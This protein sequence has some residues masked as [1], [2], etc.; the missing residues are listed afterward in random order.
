G[1]NRI[2]AEFINP[3]GSYGAMCGNGGRA[4]TAFAKAMG[5]RTDADTDILLTL[6][7][8]RYTVRFRD[9]NTIEIDFP[10]PRAEQDL[11][12]ASLEGIDIP[13]YYVDVHSDHVVI[14]AD[15]QRVDPRPLRHH[16]HFPRGVNVNMVQVIGGVVQL[17][18]YERGVEGVTGACGTG[19]LSTALALWRSG[20]C[21]DDVYLVPPS[22][23]ALE[24]A[25]HHTGATVTGL[26]LRGDALEDAPPVEFDM[27]HRT[28]IP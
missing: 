9:D 23:R 27:Q 28:Y 4:I 1:L 22:G 26:T 21:G 11:P 12:V 15:P 18:T 14:D 2:R 19:A 7:G 20:R 17:A 13:A 10:A 25:I 16:P 8:E 5:L 6:S 24:V 3:D